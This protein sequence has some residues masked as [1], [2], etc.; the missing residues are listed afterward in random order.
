M[1]KFFFEKYPQIKLRL[2]SEIIK[3]FL[4]YNL[5]AFAIQKYIFENYNININVNTIRNIPN[6]IRAVIYRYYYI[7]Y[8]VQC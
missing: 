8:Q 3:I 6:D 4:C 7:D 2:L 1:N 5:N